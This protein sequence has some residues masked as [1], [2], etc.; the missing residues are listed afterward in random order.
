MR[1]YLSSYKFGDH[2]DELK[3]LAP[4]VRKVAIIANA[5]DFGD[6]D[7]V[8][9]S[10]EKAQDELAT[11]GLQAESLDLREYFGK[12]G[13]LEQALKAYEMVW[14]HGGNAFLLRR[15]YKQSG[16]DEILKKRL[17][18]DTLVYAGYSAAVVVVTPTLK[19]V[20]IVDDPAIVPE[21]YE[22]AVELSGLGFI[23]YVVAVHYK[24]EHPES[25]LIDQYITYCEK[26]SLPYKTLRDGEVMIVDG[27]NE[28]IL[29]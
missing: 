18:E 4:D 26:N 13:E 2:A 6:R 14:V 7:C 22:N 5:I 27:V 12:T 15:A 1:M 17:A 23:P 3:R 19:G 21:G 10:V 16:F 8:S 9:E 25:E 29:K 24:S 28:K 20:D 11:L